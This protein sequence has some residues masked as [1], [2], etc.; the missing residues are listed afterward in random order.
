MNA[1]SETHNMVALVKLSLS[2]A[3]KYHVAH[4][5]P[6]RARPTASL[7]LPYKV[8]VVMH[9]TEGAYRYD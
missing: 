7:P 8:T 3:S 6:P 5:T 1:W 4:Q 9:S 2:L